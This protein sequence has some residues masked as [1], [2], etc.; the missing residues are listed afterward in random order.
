[1][2][3]DLPRTPQ[4]QPNDRILSDEEERERFRL[5]CLLISQPNGSRHAGKRT[6]SRSDDVDNAEARH[7]GN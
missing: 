4:F 3:T 7:P 2:K 6:L 1:M 5:F